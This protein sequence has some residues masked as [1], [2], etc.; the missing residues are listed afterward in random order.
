MII[1][2]RIKV[3]VYYWRSLRYYRPNS[4]VPMGHKGGNLRD[5]NEISEF[6][7]ALIEFYWI[8]NWSI[9]DWKNVTFIY[10]PIFLFFLIPD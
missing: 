4:D 2:N 8:N 9:K 10:I 3:L 7:M 6:P 1:R 5:M